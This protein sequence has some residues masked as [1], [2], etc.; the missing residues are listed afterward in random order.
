MPSSVSKISGVLEE[1]AF[2]SQKG[3]QSNN[4]GRG[5]N[6]TRS[7]SGEVSNSGGNHHSRVSSAGVSRPQKRGSVVCE[8]HN[9]NGHTK[10]QCYKLIGYP[11]D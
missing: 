4:N 1:V 2:F 5:F 3:S 10:K 6:S 8:F 7:F 11:S 9:Y